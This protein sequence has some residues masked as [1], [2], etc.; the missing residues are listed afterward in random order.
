MR[1]DWRNA[2]K[3]R[4]P[5][6][7]TKSIDLRIL[8]ISVLLAGVL[9]FLPACISQPAMEL[10]YAHEVPPLGELPIDGTWELQLDSKVAPMFKIEWGRMY[11]YANYGSRAKHGMVVAKNIRQLDSL[12][13]GCEVATGDPSGGMVFG[14]GEMEVISEDELLIRYFRNPAA[15]FDEE[16]TETYLKVSLENER[17]FRAEL[18][19]GKN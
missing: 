5:L 11:V 19:R 9:A 7:M 12:R 4:L 2:M 13:Y 1:G 15:G 14:L 17:W 6:L 18:S 16:K 10:P 3:N 8:F